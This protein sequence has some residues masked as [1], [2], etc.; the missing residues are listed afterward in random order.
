MSGDH[1]DK[2]GFPEGTNIGVCGGIGYESGFGGGGQVSENYTITPLGLGHING[3]KDSRVVGFTYDMR[4]RSKHS[5]SGRR[6]H[7]TSTPMRL[8]RACARP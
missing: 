4:L 6:K 1:L 5:T 7:F 8:A 2:I 3:M